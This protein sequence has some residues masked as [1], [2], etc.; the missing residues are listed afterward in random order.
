M[1]IQRISVSCAKSIS[2]IAIKNASEP[3]KIYDQT[4]TAKVIMRKNAK[5]C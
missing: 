1:V 3:S 2:E 4:P 5:A